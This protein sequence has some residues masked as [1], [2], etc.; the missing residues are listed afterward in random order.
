M[1]K[2][3]FNNL[4]QD[5]YSFTLENGL[6][7]YLIPFKDKKNYYAVLGTKYG[8]NDIEFN[9][10]NQNIK[11]PFGTAHFLEHKMF[12]Q[13]DGIDPF[14]FFSKSGVNTNASTTFNNT[15]Y[16]I[17]GINDIYKNINYLLDFVYSPY[18]TDKNVLKEKGIIKEEILMYEDDPE[19]ALDD[20]MRKNLFYELPV[21]EKIAGTISSIEN[22]TKEDLYNAY[23]TFY[24][25]SN[26]FLIIG[27]NIDP[28]EL[29]KLIKNHEKLNSIKK[30]NEIKRKKYK[31]PSD[32]S[33]E[34]TKLY[35]NVKVPKVRY[36]M[37]INTN[38]FKNFSSIEINM[39]M[40]VVISSLF[41]STSDF[42]EKVLNEA[43]TTGFYVEKNNY[44]NFLTLDITAESDK[45][46]MFIDEVKDNLKNIKIKKDELER[47]KK[48]WIA[49]EIRMIDNVEATVDNI[50]S[51]LIL[52]DKVYDNRIDIIKE[53]NIKK[54]N[55]FLKELDLS[56]QSLVMVLPKEEKDLF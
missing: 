1:E 3:N 10:D 52:Y 19:W 30:N 21:R 22:I 25:P 32:V 38:N 5:M 37:K 35:M 48:V 40:G 2:T 36:S 14:K 31:E 53:L 24:N 29:E 46:D 8:S 42:K 4:D 47:I 20:N 39:Y 9:I 34:F 56:N 16:Y 26:M 6:R 54:L 15:R 7:V 41:G 55:K 50:Y 23:N 27:G 18:F 17:W 43:L 45:A 51:D 13:E 28:E 11:T 49:S 33:E 12:E 44:D